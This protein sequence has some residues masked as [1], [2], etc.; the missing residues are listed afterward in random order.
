V[1]SSSLQTQTLLSYQSTH[2]CG[3]DLS[4]IMLVFQ[5]FTPMSESLLGVPF[6][7]PH[8][9]APRPIHT[10][11]CSSELSPLRAGQILNLIRVCC[12]MELRSHAA[13]PVTPRGEPVLAM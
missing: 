8:H 13:S 11:G 1:L 12:V 5:I 3:V 2:N 10:S 9:L 7:A 6:W 4:D